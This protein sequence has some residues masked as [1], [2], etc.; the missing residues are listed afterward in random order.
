MFNP[1]TGAVLAVVTVGSS[2]GALAYDPANQDVYVS[3]YASNSVSVI[4]SVTNAVV[5]TI[6]SGQAPSWI[7][8]SPANKD[9]YVIDSN[10]PYGITVI[11]GVTNVLVT[12]IQAQSGSA[13]YDPANQTSMP[14]R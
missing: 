14:S 12:T 6:T 10:Y 9:L 8:Y 2:P 4:S 1:S 13:A 5:A 7:T 11:N 3:N